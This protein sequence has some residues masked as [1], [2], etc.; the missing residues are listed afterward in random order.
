MNRVVRTA[1]ALLL[2]LGVNGAFAQEQVGLD[3]FPELKRFA[4]MFEMDSEQVAQ[5][6]KVY[7][8]TSEKN[9]DMRERSQELQAIRKEKANAASQQ[10]KEA[11]KEEMDGIA[12]ERQKLRAERMEHMEKVLNPEQLEKFQAWRKSKAE[13]MESE[14]M[15]RKERVEKAEEMKEKEVKE[16]E[17]M[18]KEQ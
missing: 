14:E 7:Q 2:I 12:K 15:M 4:K 3:E 10:D 17:S 11:W 18:K 6:E 1:A 8:M 13:K 5:M 9:N 16:K